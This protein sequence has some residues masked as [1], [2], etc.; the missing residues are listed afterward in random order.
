MVEKR[1]VF[2]ILKRNLRDRVDKDCLRKVFQEIAGVDEEWEELEGITDHMGHHVSVM[3]E[4][5]CDLEALAKRGVPLRVFWK[6]GTR[7]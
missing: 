1:I 7:G 4:D 2:Q 6:S 5:I 3:C